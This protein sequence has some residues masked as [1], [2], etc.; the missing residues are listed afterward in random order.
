MRGC[1]GLGLAAALTAGA[2]A[3]PRPKDPPPKGPDIVGRW[4]LVSASQG[5]EPI[6]LRVVELDY[7]F[8]PDGRQVVRSRLGQ[9]SFEYRYTV[10]RDNSPPTFDVRD[11]TGGSA[12][13]RGIYTVEGKTL[14]ICY[15]TDADVP[16]PTKLESPAGSKAELRVFTRSKK[17]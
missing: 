7:E 17:D 6:P 8:T 11:K 12:N 2:V 3:A 4:V 10:D 1:I 5:G 9:V 16:R 14:T 13:L 15:V